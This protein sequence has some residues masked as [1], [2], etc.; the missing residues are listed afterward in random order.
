M[1]GHNY[2]SPEE[3]KWKQHKHPSIDERINKIWY[4]HKVEYYFVIKRNNVLTQATTWIN[5]KNIIETSQ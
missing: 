1:E 4:I 3:E 5:L 2:P